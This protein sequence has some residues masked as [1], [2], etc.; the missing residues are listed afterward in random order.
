MCYSQELSSQLYPA[1]RPSISLQMFIAHIN[2]MSHVQIIKLLSIL[3]PTVF[4]ANRIANC[5]AL[6]LFSVLFHISGFFAF[7]WVVFIVYIRC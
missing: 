6:P 3:S 7:E 1:P 2:I 5:S 4:H